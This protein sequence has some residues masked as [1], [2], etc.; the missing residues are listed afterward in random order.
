M[1]DHRCGKD[2]E[3]SR[4]RQVGSAS[5]SEINTIRPIKL[6]TFKAERRNR[7]INDLKPL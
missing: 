2:E 7:N 1:A 3:Q 5:S 4:D 6:P